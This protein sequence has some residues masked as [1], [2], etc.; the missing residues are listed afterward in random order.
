MHP[1][2]IKYTS[3]LLISGKPSTPAVYTGAWGGG[4]GE[5]PGVL[6]KNPFLCTTGGRGGM[7][8]HLLLERNLYKTQVFRQWESSLLSVP[9]RQDTAVGLAQCPPRQRSRE[10]LNRTE[11]SLTTVLE[12]ILIL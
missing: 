11:A 1:L 10:R 12:M 8:L 2:P 7:F 4:S 5:D 3:R 6:E 9:G